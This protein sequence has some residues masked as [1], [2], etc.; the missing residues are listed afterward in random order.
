MKNIIIVIFALIICAQ[1]YKSNRTEL[2]Q[3]RKPKAEVMAAS[4]ITPNY[5]QAIQYIEFNMNLYNLA[6]DSE[7]QDLCNNA[8]K[9]YE[10]NEYECK[11]IEE[12]FYI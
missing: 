2:S 8:I 3:E 1:Y 11:L 9:L 7:I 10:L 6:T 12:Y 4:E 5:S